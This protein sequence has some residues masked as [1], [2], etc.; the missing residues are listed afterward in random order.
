MTERLSRF[1]MLAA[2][3]ALLSACAAETV[4]TPTTLYDQLGG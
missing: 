2:L 3:F 4:R 1:L